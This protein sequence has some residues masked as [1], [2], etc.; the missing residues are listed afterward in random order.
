LE[1]GKVRAIPGEVV[2]HR[3]RKIVGR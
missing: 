1:S 3:I 2:S